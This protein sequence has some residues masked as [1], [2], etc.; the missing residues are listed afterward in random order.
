METGPT[1]PVCYVTT[2]G[3]I[4]G[5]DHTIEIWYVELGG[6]LYL[7]SGNRDRAD[8]VKNLRANPSVTV[9]IAP[10]GPGGERSKPADYI[11]KVAPLTNE[12]EVRHAM[13]ERYRGARP[14][15]PLSRWAAES[16]VVQLC[17]N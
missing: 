15:D 5:H 6:C 2:R 1:Q 14:G 9:V 8:W 16:L 4:S 13:D 7:L 3:R 11:A 10:D 12:T 17:P